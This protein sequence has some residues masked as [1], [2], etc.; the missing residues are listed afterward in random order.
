[1][2]VMNCDAVNM[3]AVKPL[4]TLTM[5][6]TLAQ[7]VYR[8]RPMWGTTIYARCFHTDARLPSHTTFT[9]VTVVDRHL[10]VA[11]TLVTHSQPPQR[12]HSDSPQCWRST[13]SRRNYIVADC[14]EFDPPPL[15]SASGRN[16][17]ASRL[18]SLAV[19]FGDFLT[20]RLSSCKLRLCRTNEHG[21]CATFPASRSSF[22]NTLQ[23]WWNCSI[24]NFFWTLRLIIRFRLARQPTKTKLLAGIS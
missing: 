4:V 19:I 15:P 10:R 24:C 6:P 16:P 21:F 14:T 8:L 23:K 2:M 5:P 17:T 12:S 18:Y 13:Q 7:C 1:M 3:A 9:V 20:L 11:S 22:T